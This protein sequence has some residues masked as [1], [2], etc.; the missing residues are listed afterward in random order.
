MLSHYAYGPR[1]ARP[2]DSKL[3]V[4]APIPSNDKHS[5]KLSHERE[6]YAAAYWQAGG[7]SDTIYIPTGRLKDFFKDEG[8][9]DQWTE[10]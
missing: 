9:K 6:D 1:S 7:C 3:T 8:A 4:P 5:A 10:G 2:C